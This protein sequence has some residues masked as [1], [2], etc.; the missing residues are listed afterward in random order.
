MRAKIFTAVAL[1]GPKEGAFKDLL[2]SVQKILGKQLGDRFRP[3]T[4]KQIHST[5][6]RLDWF[7]DELSGLAVNR[8]YREVVGVA[9]PMILDRALEILQSSLEPPLHIRIGGFRAGHE[10]TFSSRGVHPYQRM[11]SVQ[12]DAFV[13]L[14]WPR[15]TVVSGISKKPLDD[16]RREMGEANILHWY[17]ESPADIDNDFHMVVGHHAAAAPARTAA[18]V[19]AVREHL[20][21]HPIDIAVGSQQVTIIA[22]DSPTLAPALFAGQITKDNSEIIE[23]FR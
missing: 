4:L 23:L 17:H 14:G 8:R 10:A 2:Q 20:S 13:I 1:Y 21:E 16:L 3:Y 15:S 12:G 6:I 18:A 19:A 7:A 9:R 22:S 5:L 11:F